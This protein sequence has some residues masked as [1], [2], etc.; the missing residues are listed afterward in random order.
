VGPS[1]IEGR[2][3]QRI[4]IARGKDVRQ[5]EMI[6]QLYAATILEKSVILMKEIFK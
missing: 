5:E 4:V 3:N 2:L 1:K 6:T